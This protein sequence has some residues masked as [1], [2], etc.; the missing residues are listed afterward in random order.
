[1]P[2]CAKENKN[3]MKVKKLSKIPIDQKP[4]YEAI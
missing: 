1:M 4:I 3:Q 2:L